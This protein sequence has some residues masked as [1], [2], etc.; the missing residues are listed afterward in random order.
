MKKLLKS[1]E[2]FKKEYMD[3][4]R[5]GTEMLCDYLLIDEET[6]TGEQV[7]ISWHPQTK[8][9]H[10]QLA[11]ETDMF[12]DD[13]AVEVVADWDMV[14]DGVLAEYHDALCDAAVEAYDIYM[15]EV[16]EDDDT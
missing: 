9:I 4:V 13:E 2:A 8:D 10:D 15:E 16:G 3:A 12:M 7:Q 6:G 5:R 11:Y 14:F 1:Y